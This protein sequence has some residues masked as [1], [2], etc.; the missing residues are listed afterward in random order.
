MLVDFHS[1]ILP[2][3][4]DGTKNV[5]ESVQILDMMSK[6]GVD[7]VYCTPHF[8]PHKQSA[9]DF[10]RAR[11]QAYGR[12]VTHLKPNHPKLKMGAEVL[13][14]RSMLTRDVLE[15]LKLEGTDFVLLEMPYIHFSQNIY[16]GVND[17]ADMSGVKVLIAH[18]ERYLVAN[19]EDEV[20]E[21]MAGENVLGQINC[22]SLRKMSERRR[23][24]NFIKNGC[25]QALGTDYHRIER[26]YALM[27]EGVSILKR[28]LPRELFER[29]IRT[30]EMIAENCDIDEI[31][32]I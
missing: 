14:S 32:E 9:E 31:L 18:L 20:A 25:V 15:K 23:C 2:G 30:S 4:D 26:G 1:H 22:T 10:I 11:Q 13:M 21:L 12:L 17:I 19:T 5:E 29:L 27:D 6:T 8:Y 16:D 28:K 3:I 24:M 7:V